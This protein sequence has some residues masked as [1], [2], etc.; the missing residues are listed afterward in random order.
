MEEFINL[1]QI[2]SSFFFGVKL[3]KC[4]EKIGIE[5]KNGYMKFRFDEE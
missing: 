1:V 4:N 3:F 5:K 2:M